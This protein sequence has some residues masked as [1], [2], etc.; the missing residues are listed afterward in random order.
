MTKYTMPERLD[1]NTAPVVEGEMNELIAA[2]MP[3]QLVC[4]FSKTVYVS[5]AGLRIML[6]MTK[7]MKTAGGEF[8]LCGMQSQVFDVFKLSGFEAFIDIRDSVE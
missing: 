7:K 5:S 8:I 1:V 6:V 4:D 3:Q 2:E